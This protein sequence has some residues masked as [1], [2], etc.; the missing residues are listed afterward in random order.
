MEKKT[1]YWIIGILVFFVLMLQ[2]YAS[3]TPQPHVTKQC[4]IECTY[5]NYDCIQSLAVDMNYFHQL[6]EAKS[7][8]M[9]SLRACIREC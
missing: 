1:L 2:W 8:C 3:T 6:I 9:R 7:T 4:A 5:D